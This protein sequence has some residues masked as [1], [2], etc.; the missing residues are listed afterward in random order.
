MNIHDASINIIAIQTASQDDMIDYIMF[1]NDSKDIGFSPDI[2]TIVPGAKSTGKRFTVT[3][4]QLKAFPV[5]RL[6]N[7][8]KYMKLVNE[9]ENIEI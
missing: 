6:R 5:E 9:A 8:V 4:E 2:V 1:Y 7:L 3:E